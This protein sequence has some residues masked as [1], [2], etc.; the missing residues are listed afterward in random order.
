MFENRLEENG[1]V[2]G[3][4]DVTSSAFPSGYTSGDGHYEEE[5]GDLDGDGDLDIYGL[6]WLAGLAST[7]AHC[8]ATATAPSAM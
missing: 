6:N 2:L 8:A 3:F 4:R 7:T 1:G 5:M